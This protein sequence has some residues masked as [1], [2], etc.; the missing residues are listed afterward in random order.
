MEGEEESPDLEL[1]PISSTVLEDKHLESHN[2]GIVFFL[3]PLST[4]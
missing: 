3:L 2:P 4:G 1:D